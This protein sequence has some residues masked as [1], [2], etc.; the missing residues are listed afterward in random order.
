MA[1]AGVLGGCALAK[2]T[3]EGG[4]GEMLRKMF[5]VQWKATTVS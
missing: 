1:S 3:Y 5:L 2:H 4:G